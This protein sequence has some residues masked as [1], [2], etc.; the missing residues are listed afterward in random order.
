MKKHLIILFLLISSTFFSQKKIEVIY[1]VGTNHPKFTKNTNK[2]KILKDVEYLLEGNQQIS[3]FSIINKE[4]Q[5]FKD[6]VISDKI[7]VSNSV[8]YKDLKKK[9]SFSYTE[10]YLDK[11]STIISYNYNKYNWTIT[12]ESKKIGK[13]NCFKATT[14]RKYLAVSINEYL[15]E[16]IV[17][18]F[19]PEIAVPFGPN[20]Y[21]G[22]P[23]LVLEVSKNNFYFIANSV[24]ISNEELIIK[25]PEAKNYMTN[26]EAEDYSVNFINK[27]RKKRKSKN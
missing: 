26:K 18:W 15:N 16:T 13:Y 9:E 7:G 6:N 10:T 19:T 12:K 5:T 14:E 23:G 21:S 3:K 22:L 27:Y 11:K 4:N 20:D 25:K 8:F 2:I 24:K 1:S 17:V